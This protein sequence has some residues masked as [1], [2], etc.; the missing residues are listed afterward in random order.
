[1]TELYLAPPGEPSPSA[2]RARRARYQPLLAPRKIVVAV[3]RTWDIEDA[4]LFSRERSEFI[5]VPRTA[6]AYLLRHICCLSTAKIGKILFRDHTSIVHLLNNRAPD[7]LTEP[8]F[9]TRI[10]GIIDQ[11]ALPGRP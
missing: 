11:L 1:M 5:I 7:L 8:L 4:Q 10:D 3:C 2:R 6:A 9:K